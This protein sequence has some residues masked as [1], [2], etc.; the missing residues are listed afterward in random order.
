MILSKLVFLIFL[1][2]IE[3]KILILLN[4]KVAIKFTTFLLFIAKIFTIIKLF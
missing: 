1:I 4:K 3:I 2:L